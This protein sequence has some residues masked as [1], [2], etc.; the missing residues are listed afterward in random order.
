MGNCFDTPTQHAQVG[1]ITTPPPPK[2]NRKEIYDNLTRYLRKSY[3]LANGLQ[4]NF[5][6]TNVYH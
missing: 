2:H 5:V 6:S 1:C 4:Q 3:D